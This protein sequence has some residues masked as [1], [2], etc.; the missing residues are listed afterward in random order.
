MTQVLLLEQRG[1]R[2]ARDTSAGFDAILP[3]GLQSQPPTLSCTPARRRAAPLPLLAMLLLGLS[4]RLGLGQTPGTTAADAPQAAASTK[5]V[6][7]GKAP[8]TDASLPTELADLDAPRVVRLG[9]RRLLQGHPESALQAYEHAKTMAP[10]AREIDFA[11]GLAE[12][13][14]GDYE[15]ARTL[16]E[17]AATATN[18]ALV[19]D[20]MYS[21][22]ATY[23]QQ[24]L[25]NTD[26]PKSKIAALEQAMHH[27]QTVLAHQPGH[28]AARDANFKAATAW[29][30]LKQRMQ[31][32][33]QNQQQQDDKDKKDK[34]ED[35]D[36]SKQDQQQ[37]QDDQKEQDQQKQDQQES[38]QQQQQQDQQ[39][40]DKDQQD[41]DADQSEQKPS[42][43]DQDK[44]QQEDKQQ[45]QQRKEDVSKEQAERQ[46][47]EMMQ[48]IRDRKKKQRK[49]QRPVGIAPVDKDW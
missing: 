27:Y 17:N 13:A 48:A 32:Q 18:P 3:C 26:D 47:R 16:F 43:A 34:D 12:Y 2:L 49:Q 6:L 41:S 1:T 36:K 11:E 31:Q 14:R 37:Q 23:H 38:D 42:Q 39:P 29:R 44:T 5:P 21:V 15:R 7:S 24:A 20:A 4:A 40:Q 30:Q 22:A 19:D 45:A 35:Q 25:Q 28:E 46:L 10:D 8:A 9:N 33:Q